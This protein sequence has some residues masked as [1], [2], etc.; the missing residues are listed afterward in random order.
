MSDTDRPERAH[1]RAALT[2]RQLEILGLV[3]AGLS[4][5]DIAAR[6]GIAQGTVKAH[7]TM[8]YSRLGVTNRVQATRHYLEHLPPG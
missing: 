1:A 5:R 8:I 2:P 6:L 4:T 7:L 3:A